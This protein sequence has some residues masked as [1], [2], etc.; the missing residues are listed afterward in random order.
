M[1]IASNILYV[2]YLGDILPFLD[3]LLIVYL[4]TSMARTSLGPLEFVQDI[5]SSSHCRSVSALGQN[6]NGDN[7]R[8]SILFSIN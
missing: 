8:M 1:Y 3:R 4:F 6:A 7:L 5:G 2:E